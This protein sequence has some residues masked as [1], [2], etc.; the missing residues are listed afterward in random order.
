VISGSRHEVE[1]NCALLGYDTASSC[2]SLPTFRDNISV[3]KSR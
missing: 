1:E 2:N 3:P